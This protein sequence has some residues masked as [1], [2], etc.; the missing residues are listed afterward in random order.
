MMSDDKN[1]SNIKQ[2]DPD[3]INAEVAMKRAAIKAREIAGKTGTA[4]VTSEN[5][6]IREEYP[7]QI[8]SKH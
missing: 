2:R 8:S 7:N 3:L 1:K 4:V 6:V 5:K